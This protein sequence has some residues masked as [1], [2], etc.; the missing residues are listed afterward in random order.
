M[1]VLKKTEF[2]NPILRGH[3]KMLSE[4]EILSDNTQYLIK[5]MYHTIE[6]KKFGVGLAAPQIGENYQR[7][8]Q[9]PL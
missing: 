8:G 9:S 2:G 5:N 3:T 7:R 1:Q 4:E 6:T